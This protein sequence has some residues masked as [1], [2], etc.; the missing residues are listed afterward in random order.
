MKI[1]LLQSLE[2]L[3]QDVWGREEEKQNAWQAI[4]GSEGVEVVGFT[5][6]LGEEALRGQGVGQGKRVPKGI[7]YF[8]LNATFTG[9]SF[10]CITNRALFCTLKITDV[11]MNIDEE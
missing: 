4:V 10:S 6:H 3:Q 5:V 2:H 8:L 9:T 1:R 7:P 11:S